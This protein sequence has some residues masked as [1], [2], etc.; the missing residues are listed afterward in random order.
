MSIL[1]YILFALLL[2]GLWITEPLWMKKNFDTTASPVDTQISEENHQKAKHLTAESGKMK[3][4]EAKFGPKPYGR[5][6]TGVP[7]SIYDYW[8][9]T[10]EYPDSLE[11]E[12]CRPIRP[13]P[14]GWTTVCRYR[15]KT[16]SGSFQLMQDTFII[17]DS[18][19]HK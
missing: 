12:R 4:L 2:L 11:E 15:V 19:A 16:S 13:G 3:E 10:L 8:A 5:H 6:S 7:S 1:K 17:K 9:K 18:V 14:R